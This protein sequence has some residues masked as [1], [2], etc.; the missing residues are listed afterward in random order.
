MKHLKSVKSW[1][2]MPDFPYAETWWWVHSS[3]E[4]TNEWLIDCL[5][6]FRPEI[7]FISFTPSFIPFSIIKDFLVSKD[8]GIFFF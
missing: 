8:T 1:F 6:N 4:I 3:R 2:S 7:S 5:S